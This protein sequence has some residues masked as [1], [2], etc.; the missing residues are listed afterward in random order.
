M[1]GCKVDV[2]IKQYMENL[3]HGAEE[4]EE[5]NADRGI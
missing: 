4:Q 3:A 1:E 2:R 5:A